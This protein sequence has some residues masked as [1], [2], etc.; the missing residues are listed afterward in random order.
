[1][2]KISMGSALIPN[3]TMG[4]WMCLVVVTLTSLVASLTY[5]YIEVPARNYLNKRFGPKALEPV[6]VV[7]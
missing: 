3:F 5:K 2:G 4:L 6:K 7:S 1:M